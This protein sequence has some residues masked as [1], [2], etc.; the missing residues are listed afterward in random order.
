MSASPKLTIYVDPPGSYFLYGMHGH[1]WLGLQKEDGVNCV[2]GFYPE[3]IRDDTKR[4]T[5]HTI[6]ITF[7]I[8]PDHFQ[9]LERLFQNPGKYNLI[10]HNCIDFV[11]K[12]L[13]ICHIPHPN[14]RLNGVSLTHLVYDWILKRLK[15][16]SLLRGENFLLDSFG[17]AFETIGLEY[18]EGYLVE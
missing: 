15:K 11:R 8:S 10:T 1:V 6:S 13:D 2:I 18:E 17:A 7:P 3:G 14:F 9:E 5:R 12:A 16:R 4:S